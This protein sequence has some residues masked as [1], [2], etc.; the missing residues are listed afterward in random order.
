MHYRPLLTGHGVKDAVPGN[1]YAA[2]GAEISARQID[3]RRD[4]LIS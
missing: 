2:I 4:I 3:A 1:R